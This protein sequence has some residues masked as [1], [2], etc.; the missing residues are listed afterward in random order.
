MDLFAPFTNI[1]PVTKGWSGD[2]K[3]CVTD[4]DGAKSLLRI[5]PN[6][7]AERLESMFALLRE[8]ESLGV[9]MCELR[10]SGKCDEGHYSL[11]RWIEGEDLEPSL[12]LLSETEQYEL[13]WE[14][15]AI[16]RRIH[17][18]PSAT[19]TEDWETRYSQKIDRNIRRYKE[20]GVR[21][22]DDALMV[23]YLQQ[24]R[25][26]LRSRSQCFQ[27]GDYHVGNMMLEEGRL[28][29]ID[30]DR[31]DFGDPWEEFNRI[32][33]SAT[34]SPHFATGQL[35]GYFVG[36]PPLLFFQVMLMYIA[37]NTL[38]A[39]PWA[40]PYGSAEVDTMLR[41]TQDVLHWF[42]DMKNPIPS[43]YLRDFVLQRREK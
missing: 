2:Q 17:S 14:S 31:F 23:E 40:I 38:G 34:V 27:H 35:R 4:A 8:V 13:G 9:P 30:F 16:L 25:H 3:F 42:D 22:S 5:Y 41:Q 7:A 6:G 20:C 18:L 21:F 39:I 10:E 15:G 43:W 33:W 19:T 29:I 12:P 24:T 28:I 11:Q 32:V 37:T 36:E 26:L 1:E